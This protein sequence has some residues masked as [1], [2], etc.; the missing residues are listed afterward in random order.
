MGSG[1]KCRIKLLAGGGVMDQPTDFYDDENRRQLYA[2]DHLVGLPDFVKTAEAEPKE[3]MAK[4]P[5]NA[6]ADPA[7]RKFPCHTKAATFLSNAYFQA[8]KTGYQ[9]A[10]ADAIQDRLTKFAAFWQIKNVCGT[11]NAAWTKMA[12]SGRQDL[13]DTDYALVYEVDGHKVRRMSMP[14]ALSVK[15]AGEYLFAN[16]FRYPYAW[17]KQ[18]ARKILSKALEWDKKAE[19]GENVAPGCLVAPPQ[20]GAGPVVGI[21][22]EL[23]RGLHDVSP[24]VG[25]VADMGIGVFGQPGFFGFEPPVVPPQ[26]N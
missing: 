3:A 8:S 12:S 24:C 17:R 13:P 16:R 14:N 10:D 2:F 23:E 21:V 19:A 5:T 9:K 22:E 11:F 18:A 4:L 20:P 7:H 26:G 6:F 1:L 25:E 15:M